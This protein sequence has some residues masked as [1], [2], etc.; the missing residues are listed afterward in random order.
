M[1]KLD[2]HTYQADDGSI[3][4]LAPDTYDPDDDDS[5]A[6]RVAAVLAEALSA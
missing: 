2:E 6:R 1:K 4:V 3:V 5:I